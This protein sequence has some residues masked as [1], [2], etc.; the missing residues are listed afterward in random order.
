M[1]APAPASK[2]LRVDCAAIKG[3][4]GNVYSLPRPAR[5]HDV[6]QHMRDKGYTGFVSGDRQGFLLSDG[7]FTW[8][9]PALR[10]AERAGQLIQKT[11]PAHLLFSEDLW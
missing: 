5:H 1:D 11:A 7:R 4:D 10:V 9:R 8:R 6:I 2:E 3:D